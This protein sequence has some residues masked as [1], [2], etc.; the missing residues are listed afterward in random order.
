MFQE[1]L[2][3]LAILDLLGQQDLK[4][5]GEIQVL[6]G[7]L[8]TRGQVA[9]LGMLAHLVLQDHLEVLEIQDFLEILD[10][11]ALMDRQEFQVQLE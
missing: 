10:H 4:E 7:H 9:Q 1:A 11:R 5:Q 2:E 3:S 8:E 6:L